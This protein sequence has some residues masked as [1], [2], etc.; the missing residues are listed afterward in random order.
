MKYSPV[1]LTSSVIIGICLIGNSCKEQNAPDK[2]LNSDRIHDH[3]GTIPKEV[4]TLAYNSNSV[5]KPKDQTPS[6][7][8]LTRV[9]KLLEAQAKEEQLFLE[10]ATE[11]DKLERE[12]N[13]APERIRYSRQK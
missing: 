9:N 13:S 11:E 12:I 6:K 10:T 8:D 4:G 1:T 3:S 2:A 7:E 5:D